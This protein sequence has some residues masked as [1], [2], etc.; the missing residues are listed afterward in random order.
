MSQDGSLIVRYTCDRKA[1]TYGNFEVISFNLKDNRFEFSS[2][3]MAQKPKERFHANPELC[4]GCHDY[5]GDGPADLRPNWNMYPEWRGMFGSHD[6]FFPRRDKAE[7]VDVAHAPGWLPP[8]REKERANFEQFIQTKVQ[9]KIGSPDPCYATLPWLKSNAGTP[10]PELFAL[11]PYGTTNGSAQ[12]RVYATRPN[13]KF[14][15][16]LSKLLARR[17]HRRL[18]AEPQFKDLNLYLALESAYCTD[19]SPPFKAGGKAPF[20]KQELD[21]MIAKLLPNYVRPEDTDAKPVDLR[22]RSFLHHDPRHSSSRAQALFGV[23]K[24]F[25]WSG[26]EWTMVPFEYDQPQYETGAGPGANK[27]FPADLPLTAYTQFEILD[28][29]VSA[30]RDPSLRQ[31]YQKSKGESAD[32]GEHFACVDRL[33]GPVSFTSKEAWQKLCD[34]LIIA[35]RKADQIV[36]AAPRIRGLPPSSTRGTS[37]GIGRSDRIPKYDPKSGEALADYLKR[38]NQQLKQRGEYSY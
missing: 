9:P 28:S 13:L 19:P 30:L 2:V 11:W 23:W 26:G 8:D 22:G 34:G 12:K 32:F 4:S 31:T 24:A 3:E 25:G 16:V 21:Q 33:A 5:G 15:E 17:N 36:Q 20:S 37:R 27:A 7:T 18:Q 6:D 35:A 29:A 1:P 14:T 38:V 10:V